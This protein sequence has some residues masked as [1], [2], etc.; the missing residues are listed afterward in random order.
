M[1]KRSP[2]R[3]AITRETISQLHLARGGEAFT[4]WCSGTVLNDTVYHP[5]PSDRC[6]AGCPIQT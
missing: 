4:Y 5:A 1:Q 2:R 3:L 6:T